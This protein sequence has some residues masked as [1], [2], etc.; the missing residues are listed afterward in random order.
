MDVTFIC[1]HCKQK[2][3]G[4]QPIRFDGLDL[5][6]ECFQQ[7]TIVCEDC[8]RRIWREDN[9]GDTFYL[10]SPC[11]DRHYSRC[12]ECD[13]LIH[14]SGAF[15]LPSRQDEPLCETCYDALKDHANI[16]EYRY[17]PDPVFHGDGPLYLGVELEIDGGG[18]SNYHAGKT[19]DIGN[20]EEENIY[21]KHDGSLEE[22][23]EIVTHPMSLDYHLE[24]MPWEDILSEA[25]HLGYFSHDTET[26]GLHVHVSRAGLGDS[27]EAQDS[28]IARILYFFEKHWDKLLVFSRRTEEQIARWAERYGYRDH[29]REILTHAKN[30]KRGDRY[31]C[32]N[33]LNRDTI[34]F[35]IFR[36]TLCLNTL[37]ATLQLVHRLCCLAYSLSDEEM[38]ALTW[39]QF[40]G[41]CHQRELLRYLKQRRLYSGEV[42]S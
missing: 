29:P 8:G 25:R 35:R 14:N 10:C 42:H 33:L 2:F 15:Y 13:C 7:E 18:E 9:C 24:Q 3:A 36:G 26:C 19:L 11:Y 27:P 38:K 4:L 30:E 32:V 17:S 6:Q 41:T 37:A 5:C 22:G 28:T 21:C 31:C 20:A 1:G 40:L 16:H 39:E 12:S 34:E 23:F